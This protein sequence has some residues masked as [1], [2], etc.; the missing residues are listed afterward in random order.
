MPG[1]DELMKQIQLLSHAA[2]VYFPSVSCWPKYE[3]Q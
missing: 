1:T 2:F 3:A